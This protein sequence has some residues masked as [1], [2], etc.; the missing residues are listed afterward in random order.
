MKDNKLKK[1]VK[2]KDHLSN[3][4][5]LINLNVIPEKEINKFLSFYHDSTA[6]KNYF[7]LYEK[8]ISEG[9][10]FNNMINKC[11][12]FIKNCTICSMK[13]KNTFINCN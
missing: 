7:I 5:K 3:Y 8:I 11:I 10:Y 2:L 13:N 9:F 1:F 6:H 4:T 12:A